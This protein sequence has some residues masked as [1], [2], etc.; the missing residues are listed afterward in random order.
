M[1]RLSRRKTRKKKLRL[2][3]EIPKKSTLQTKKAVHKGS[4]G[5]FDTTATQKVNKPAY[6]QNWTA[7]NTSQTTEKVRFMKFLHD[8]CKGI[9]EPEQT[10]GRPR[11]PLRDMVFSATFKVYSTVSSRRFISDLQDA[12][13]KGYISK[14]P[15]FN[16][17]C[18]YMELP[19]LT[20][21]IKD[22]ITASSLPLKDI[23]T[24]FAVDSSGFSTCRFVKWF[25]ARYCHEQDNHDWIK[26][27]LMC[28]VKTNIVTS[29]EISGRYEHD[30]PFFP[31]L[32]KTT[33]RNFKL[34]EVS[35]DKGYSSRENLRVVDSN[36]AMPYIPFKT[37]ATGGG[38]SILWN[39]MW[40]FYNLNRDVFLPHYHKR[41][42]IESTFS[43]IKAKFGDSI[44]CKGDIA[45][46]N[47]ALCMVL[48]HKICV[49]SQS[50][51]E[52]GIEPNLSAKS[53]QISKI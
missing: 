34:K 19:L 42:N 36:G 6:S 10:F 38:G 27:H 1:S 9:Q 44:R 12:L 43:M 17:I 45:Q 23:E 47:E 18:N 52:L 16:S 21:I 5:K 28:G 48:C 4:N 39:E 22:L 49:V 7:Y 50:M 15:H 20:P 53:L 26:V 30:A 24:D 13:N 29:I 40:H 11:L 14:L 3:P 37:S 2:V 35:A 33:A 32:V 51:Y 8:L 46:M 31:S 25:N 41:S